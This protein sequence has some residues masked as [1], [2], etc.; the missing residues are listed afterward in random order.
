MTNLWLPM[1]GVPAMG[2]ISPRGFWH[3]G[4]PEGCV[5]CE[6]AS[7]EEAP[8]DDAD[9]QPNLNAFRPRGS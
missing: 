6:A 1:P 7:P 4:S 8:G 9:P 5:K 3:P 2:H